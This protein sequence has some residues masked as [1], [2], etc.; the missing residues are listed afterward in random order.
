[1]TTKQNRS[2]TLGDRLASVARVSLAPALVLGALFL[3]ARPAGA[4]DFR[5]LQENRP[6]D[7]LAN[8]P[9][10]GTPPELLV[11]RVLIAGDSWAQYMWD[12]GSHN[13]LFDRYGQGDKRAVSLSLGSDPGPNYP[14]PEYAVS[15][16]EARQWADTANYPWI[17][18]M[19]AALEANPTIDWVILS[20]GGNDVLAGKSGGGWYKDMDL[21][22]P[23]S[24]Q[25]LFD[26]IEEDT[27]A[28]IDAALAVRPGIRVLLSSYE[29]PN[30]NV[31]F[32]CF[33][34]ACPK[35]SD[36]SRSGSD[37][38]TDQELNAMMVEVEQRRVAW[39]NATDRVDYDHSVGLMHHR[40][41]DGVS[42]P[43][44]LP[45]PGQLPPLYEPFP[46]GNPARPTL[47][48][49]FR[50]PN[51]IDAD[52]IHL[53]Y[54]GYQYKI[55]NE[56][57]TT[58]F[59]EFR[60]AATATL[61]AV[62]GTLDGWTDGT[63]SGTSGIRLGDNGIASYRGLLTFDTAAIPDGAQVTRASLYLVRS[64]GTGTNP[65]ASAA[66]GPAGIDVIRGTFGAPEVEPSD[67]LAP[68]D[69]L[70][71]GDVIGSARTNG[72]AIRIDLGAAGLAALNDAGLTQF[73]VSFPAIGSGTTSDY[74]TFHDG[75]A[76]PPPSGG[77]PSLATYMSS[78]APFLDIEWSVTSSV[79]HGDLALGGP[80]MA[81]C[82]PNPLRASTT[83]RFT[84]PEAGPGRLEI[85]D[86]AGRL[87]RR[88]VDRPLPGGAHSVTW[89]RCD[90]TGNR[91]AAGVYMARIDAAG[92]SD[93]IRLVVVD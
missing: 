25:A 43:G 77:L 83:L 61:P 7:S 10:S 76:G 30:F 42:A 45:H 73:R 79:P 82:S 3:A 40:Y 13:D 74:I 54:E 86:I 36:L 80:R 41:G 89:N 51:G 37:L 6:P 47:R 14:G 23:G 56:T 38:V 58:F 1:V 20:I 70:D 26:R 17:A 87:V 48:S 62:G 49:N 69:A 35:R 84:L 19:V 85:F 60:G 72:H 32:W 57:E 11:P 21:D 81:P 16:S 67:A 55:A 71:A 39:T 8:A 63:L 24:E 90:D 52:P 2:S 31:G 9:S 33:V 50:T 29:F 12:D 68:A 66:H 5:I 34:Y 27:F 78:R 15:G 91:V 4:Q 28:I 92:L 22:S 88:L 65:F 53:D 46:G 64:A 59:P 93:A 18:N 75:E 44:V